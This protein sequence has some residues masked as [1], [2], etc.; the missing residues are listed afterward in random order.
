MYCVCL[1]S[2]VSFIIKSISAALRKKFKCYQANLQQIQNQNRKSLKFWNKSKVTYFSHGQI[3]IRKNIL[4]KERNQVHSLINRG[5]CIF[6]CHYYHSHQLI[7]KLA[8]ISLYIVL[9]HRS[10]LIKYILSDHA[11]SSH[12]LYWT[13][14]TIWTWIFFSFKKRAITTYMIIE[15]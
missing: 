3:N 9:I 4:Y 12:A 2:M 11:F 13:I 7:E 1:C 5:K 8:S 15:L 14:H 6:H 10:S